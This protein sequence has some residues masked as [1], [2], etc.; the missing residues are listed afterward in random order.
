VA[1]DDNILPVHIEVKSNWGHAMRLGLTEIQVFDDRGEQV[2]VT[3]DDV[4]VHGAEDCRGGIDVLFNGK[5]KVRICQL[6][7]LCENN[8]LT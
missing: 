7:P 5:F 6:T 4:S 1:S 8:F 2:P 3:G